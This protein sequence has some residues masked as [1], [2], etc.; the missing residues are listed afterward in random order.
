MYWTS[1][2]KSSRR[3]TKIQRANLD[4]SRVE[5]LI[6][7]GGLGAPWGLALDVA[8]G[9]MYWTDYG[10]NKV[11]RANLNGSRVEALVTTGLNRPRGLELDLV[12]GKMYWASRSTIQR[13]NLDG[14]QVEELL[15]RPNYI[16]SLVLVLPEGKMYW[17]EDV[18]ILRANLDGSQI[19]ELLA[20]R[21]G[22]A[23]GLALDLADMPEIKVNRPPV[24]DGIRKQ[25]IAEG[26]L[27]RIDLVARDP[28]GS[29]VSYEAQSNDSGVATVSVSG[30]QL[31]IS[32][33]ELGVATIA[34]MASDASGA[35]TTQTFT[36]KV[37]A[38]IPESRG[39]MY[40][41]D[42]ETD[43]IQCANLDGSQVEDLVT[44]GLH[45]PSG[46]ALDVAKGKMYWTDYG[47]DKIQRA[48]LDGSQIEELVT[49][50]LHSPS[51]L[52]LDVAKDKMYWID[53]GTDKIQRANL[54][55]SQIE[56]LVTTELGGLLSLSTLA[57]D[58]AGGKMYWTDWARLRIQRANLDGSQIEELLPD[59]NPEGLALDLAGGKMY[60]TDWITLRIQRANL[61]G[62]HVED[63]IVSGL[64]YLTIGLALDPAG[65]K[66]YWT[67]WGTNKIQRANL[68]GTR[69][70]DLVTG[71]SG[72]VGLALD[73]GVPDAPDLVVEPP[74]ANPPN[75]APS[76]SF[77]LSVA[78]HNRGNAPAPPT[79]VR[80]Y[81]SIDSTI[82]TDDTEVDAGTVSKLA[83]PSTIFK[84]IRL[85][86]PSSPGTYYYGACVQP[87]SG[88]SNIQ[89]NCS[90]ASEV[91]VAP[92]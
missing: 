54:D 10:T 41:T 68:D 32:P 22:F 9:K 7:T 61:D 42:S 62:S 77:T 17:T 63:V 91:V 6:T 25:S 53:G 23:Q 87:V 86:A 67:D 33:V 16:G 56:E 8:G 38:P 83:A 31:T 11:H 39:K 37:T 89:N 85:I 5:D 82:T 66:M 92:Q 19:E 2:G 65:G 46:L 49:T 78:I 1:W 3:E 59:I 69:V 81:L 12:G 24:L 28:E 45:S 14:T 44:T 73:I 60:W 75:P 88:E 13:A 29:E 58:L 50:G 55:G 21:L 36:V 76:Q 18:T 70:E 74:A 4:G 27:L 34:V 90:S 48:N 71:L 51:G 47:T 40:W 15:R 84:L 20:T 30:R 57:L 64:G 80:Y 52:A 35:T 72:P 26:E 79:T 43:K